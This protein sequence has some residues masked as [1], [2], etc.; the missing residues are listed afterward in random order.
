MPDQESSAPWW[1]GIVPEV[2]VTP[3]VDTDT[4]R[5]RPQQ[6]ILD[7]SFRN[8]IV[9]K[10]SALRAATIENAIRELLSDPT[11]GRDRI[12][13]AQVAERAGC[14]IGTI[15]RYFPDRV[16]MLDHVWPGRPGK[17][18]PAEPPPS[19]P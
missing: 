7:D 18:L 11:V 14:S 13:T 2:P 5:P 15:Y 16:A 10:R 9:Q 1:E 6:P 4:R 17:Y 12:T 8:P 19:T 3:E